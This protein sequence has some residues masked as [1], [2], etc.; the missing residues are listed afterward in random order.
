MII[1]RQGNKL[2]YKKMRSSC[3]WVRFY[4]HAEWIECSLKLYIKGQLPKL[5]PSLKTG[6]GWW[7]WNLTGFLV[8][9]YCNAIVSMD[10]VYYGS[11]ESDVPVAVVT[12][13]LWFFFSNIKFNSQNLTSAPFLRKHLFHVLSSIRP[14]RSPLNVSKM[15]GPW[16]PLSRAALPVS[17]SSPRFS[18][19]DHSGLDVDWMSLCTWQLWV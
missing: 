12:A 18:W 19:K 1:D 14:R 5:L 3:Q 7:W 2:S 8:I 16:A 13:V 10:P 11:R 4:M 9:G 17:W 6:T 15:A